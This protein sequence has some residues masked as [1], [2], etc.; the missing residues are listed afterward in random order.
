[1]HVLLWTKGSHENTNFDFFKWFWWTFAIFFMP[2]SKP[3]VSF[4]SN[5][6]WF[7]S[8]TN[9]TPLY[10]FRWNVVYFAQK[11]PIKVQIFLGFLVLRSKFTKI[12]NSF[13]Q[14]I[15]FS[16]NFAQQ[17]GVMRHIST[18]LFLAETFLSAK[19]AYKRINS[20]KFHQTSQKAE[21]LHCGGLLL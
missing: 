12:Q 11:G 4:S 19:V 16:S 10:F 20:V 7:S 6:A 3:Q 15:S 17:F 21:I 14:K 9:V 1:M 5:F 8:V 18:I 2:F 13:D